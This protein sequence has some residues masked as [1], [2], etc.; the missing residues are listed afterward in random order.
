MKP[1]KLLA[2]LIV[3]LWAVALFAQAE[4]REEPSTPQERARAVQLTKKL[5]KDPL[6]QT[7]TADRE[8]LTKWII[9]IPDLTVPVCDEV[10]KPALQGEVGQYRY[11]KELIA[12]QLAA[13]M[14]YIIEHPQPKDPQDQ[15][16]Y[17]IN[18]AALNSALNAYES[19]VR[20]NAKGGKWA[21][22]EDLLTRRKNGQLDEYV[23][24]ATLKCMTGDTVTASLRLNDGRIMRAD[25]DPHLPAFVHCSLKPGA[26]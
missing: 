1:R 22:L 21:P 10:L 2:A 25:I 18:R 9:E 14:S 17:A 20:S 4:T 15:D 19:I 16:D 6:G 13:G 12:Q 8:W 26:R 11:A 23:R 7:A 5:E 24:Q 3:T